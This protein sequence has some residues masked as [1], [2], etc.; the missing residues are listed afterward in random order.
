M[1]AK[2]ARQDNSVHNE[3]EISIRAWHSCVRTASQ[4]AF[5][6]IPEIS[7]SDISGIIKNRKPAGN[8]FRGPR[9]FWNP[10]LTY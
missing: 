4:G 3:I 5:V 6:V 10:S 9:F 8:D 7:R 2:R 1:R